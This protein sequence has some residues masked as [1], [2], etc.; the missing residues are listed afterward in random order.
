MISSGQIASQ[1]L[2]TQLSNTIRQRAEMVQRFSLFS[3]ISLEECAK[4]AALARQVVF[5]QGSA[6]FFAGDSLRQTVLLTAGCVK[7]TQSDREG[8]E[9][10]VRLVGPGE[11]LCVECF[12]KYS[13]FSTAWAVS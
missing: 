8:E 13:H 12:P 6:I 5:D 11:T 4:V 9:V 1:S 10:I 3:G 2:G 7:L